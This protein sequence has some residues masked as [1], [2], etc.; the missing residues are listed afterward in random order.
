MCHT[1]VAVV[2]D[3]YDATTFWTGGLSCCRYVWFTV[4]WDCPFDCVIVDSLDSPKDILFCLRFFWSSMFKAFADVRMK[5]LMRSSQWSQTF[6]CSG[7]SYFRVISDGWVMRFVH[8]LKSSRTSVKKT[9]FRAAQA[10]LYFERHCRFC[11]WW[12][13]VKA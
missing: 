12:D 2:S 13:C 7:N 11:W 10:S 8:S 1:L 5:Q 3:V 6:G 9:L 4:C